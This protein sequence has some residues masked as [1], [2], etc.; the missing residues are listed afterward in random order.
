MEPPKRGFPVKQV[1]RLE[2]KR[3]VPVHLVTGNLPITGFTGKGHPGN[4]TMT[5]AL[6]VA[7]FGL[8]LEG[9]SK[10]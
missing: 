6:F 8:K 2:K 3:P 9:G 4:Y 1:S 5:G 7:R 10:R